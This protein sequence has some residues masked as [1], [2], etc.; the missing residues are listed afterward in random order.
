MRA[1]LILPADS[2]GFVHVRSQTSVKGTPPDCAD[3]FSMS[4]QLKRTESLPSK[5]AVA[6]CPADHNCL[7]FYFSSDRHSCDR[8]S[9]SIA[10]ASQGWRCL[11]C[12]YDVCHSCHVTHSYD[13]DPESVISS[14][15]AN[16]LCSDEWRTICLNACASNK[17]FVQSTAGENT[18]FVH[19]SISGQDAEK[20][21][22]HH[23]T[24]F[25]C[26]SVSYLSKVS[27]L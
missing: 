9:C 18:L 24:K 3:S 13:A 12:N 5:V 22:G 20:W 25:A 10:A 27:L 11:E 1:S 17:H 8:C 6:T 19:F 26:S 2:R 14:H 7:P 4:L 21:S 16:G 15:S 23:G